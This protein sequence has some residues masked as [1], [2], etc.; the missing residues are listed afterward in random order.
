MWI[1][2]FLV[3]IVP[4]PDGLLLV[5]PLQYYSAKLSTTIMA[6]EC[7]LRLKINYKPPNTTTFHNDIR[8]RSDVLSLNQRYFSQ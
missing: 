8:F 1:D 5:C 3:I 6:K 4:F 2:I 7:I